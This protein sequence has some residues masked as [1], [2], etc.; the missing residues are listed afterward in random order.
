MAYRC[1]RARKRFEI[2][3]KVLLEAVREAYSARCQSIAVRELALCSAVLLC[4][5]KLESYL[6]DLFDD[7]GSSVC[8]SAVAT[9]RLP[10]RTRAFLLSQAAVL[11]AY[12][13]FISDQDEG[14]L[15]DRLEVLVGQPHWDFAID[16][17]S[18][19]PFAAS[20]VYEGRKYPS[21]DNLRRLFNRFGVSKVFNELNRVAKRDTKAMLVSFNDLRTEMAH[22]GMPVGLNATDIKQHI[23]DVRAIVGYIDRV[24][25]SHVSGSV[26]DVCWTV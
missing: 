10:R 18:V 1:S 23:R 13:H 15:L 16:G 17:R 21:P 2:E 20:V 24:F 11:S 4:S 7:W 6:Q 3:T 19:P 26:G 9:E 12:R 22:S 8:R 14:A 25:Y 5:A